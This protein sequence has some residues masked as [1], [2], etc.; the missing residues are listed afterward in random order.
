MTTKKMTTVTVQLSPE[1]LERIHK[2]ADEGELTK[3]EVI[4]RALKVHEKIKDIL[5]TTDGLFYEKDGKKTS[6]KFL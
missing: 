4:R 5:E 6:I 3:R 1:D 2:L